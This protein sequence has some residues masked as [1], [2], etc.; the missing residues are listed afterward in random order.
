MSVYIY[1]AVFSPE[2]VGY[3]IAFPDIPGCFTQGDTLE[4]CMRNANDALC[5]MLY[6]AEQNNAEIPAPSNVNDVTHAS[7]EF[8]TLIDCD[9]DWYRRFYA[10]KAVKKTL[11]IPS[12][13]N[14]LAEKNAI[15]FS[16]V[17]QDALKAQ[18][19]IS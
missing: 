5:L 19:H 17:L 14:D 9:T 18:L 3:S 10:S 16:Q 8:V 1:P 6:D 11:S 2:D 7:N 4:E 13:L 15:N 12:W